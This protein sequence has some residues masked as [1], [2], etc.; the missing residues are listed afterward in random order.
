MKV[1]KYEK[2]LHQYLS[3]MTTLF[4]QRI[5][6]STSSGI[7]DVYYAFSKNNHSYCGWLEYKVVASDRVSLDVFGKEQCGWARRHKQH[8]GST[9]ACI[10]VASGIIMMI[11]MNT[12]MPLLEEQ[13]S[14][15]KL[16]LLQQK[17]VLRKDDFCVINV[18]RDLVDVSVLSFL[19]QLKG[20]DQ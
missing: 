1:F 17:G 11:E 18:F 2:S 4:L 10:G 13:V 6:S 14:L 3:R 9:V 15:T 16:F 8:G 12:L 19:Q 5:E 7:P 20:T